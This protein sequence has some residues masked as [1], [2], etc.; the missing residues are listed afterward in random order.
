MGKIFKITEEDNY[1]F[2]SPE[3]P[4]PR[5]KRREVKFDFSSSTPIYATKDVYCQTEEKTL[6]VDTIHQN[7]FEVLKVRYFVN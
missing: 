3:L 2:T 7:N 1:N 5:K 4:R 6:A